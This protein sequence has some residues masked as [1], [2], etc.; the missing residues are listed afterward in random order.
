MQRATGPTLSALLPPGTTAIGGGGLA[1][2]Q[3]MDVAE[4]LTKAEA[5][6]KLAADRLA[7]E[8]K[9]LTTEHAAELKS[10]KETHAA[11]VK[12]LTDTYTADVKKATETHAAE[13][14]KLTDTYATG[15]TKL[16]DEHAAELKKMSDR[17]AADVK[18]QGDDHA[19][20]LKTL[21]DTQATEVKKLTAG[22]DA[23]IK[24]LETTVAQQKV[25]A[26]ALA[27]KL[28]T[29]LGNVLTPSSALDIW[30]PLLAD[31]RRPADAAPALSNANKVLA[32]A[33]ANSEDAAKA[34][35]VAGWAYLLTGELPK[36][37]DMFTAAR[38]SS[39]YQAAAGKP[40][41]KAADT[42]LASVDDPLASYR[43]PVPAATH[44]PVAAAR[45][46]DAGIRAYRAGRYADA[47]TALGEA[48]KRDA[49]DPLGW[50]FLGAAK[51]GAGRTAEA[52][53][54]FR[55]GAEREKTTSVSARVLNDALSP[56]QGAARD[57]LNLARP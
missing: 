49:T 32:T 56:I 34:R 11:E 28:K 6:A 7:A 46:L 14:K 25:E 48:T 39:A 53:E 52:K 16:K 50:Y 47:V 37:K 13:L 21:K 43:V 31:L 33:P 4:R 45:Y 19:A 12:K 44:D 23:K 18:K 1:A 27:A 26:D 41:A 51:W 29:E 22:Y 42:G 5:A 20:A 17:F 35:T 3:L 8:T 15:T 38:S 2:G 30:L 10:L 40:W 9:K 24:T 57:A 54:D 55:Q 36:A